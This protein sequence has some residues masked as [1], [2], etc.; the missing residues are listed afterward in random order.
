MNGVYVAH[1]SALG[2]GVTLAA[3]VRLA[4]HVSVGAGTNVGMG[5]V[6]HQ[7]RRIGFGAMIGMGA[8]VTRDIPPCAL[9]YGS[10][11]RVHGA[12]RVGMARAGIG[13]PVIDAWEGALRDA[14]SYDRLV[15]EVTDVDA[16]REWAVA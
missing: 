14:G 16:L 5:A 15:A 1:D 4:G 8:V 7:R 6:V 10:P 11:A 12:N 3:G 9:A 2:D 13:E